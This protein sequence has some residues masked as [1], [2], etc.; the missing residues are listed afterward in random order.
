MEKRMGISLLGY[1]LLKIQKGDVLRVDNTDL[2]YCQENGVAYF[3]L[4]PCE[5]DRLPIECRRKH[6]VPFHYI[7]KALFR[8]MEY[9]MSLWKILSPTAVIKTV[10]DLKIL[11]SFLKL[12]PLKEEPLKEEKVIPKI[13]SNWR[14]NY[15]M[16]L[17]NKTRR[18]D[19]KI[20]YL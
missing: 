12:K 19:N 8:K 1:Y 5:T 2:Q 15:I 6:E 13:Q 3:L 17:Y 4:N 16:K 9:E 11:D 10:E 14:L 18:W 20:I 7:W